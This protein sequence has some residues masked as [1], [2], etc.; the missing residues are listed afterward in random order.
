MCDYIGGIVTTSTPLQECTA[1][2]NLQA[3]IDDA[4]CYETV[5]A[6]RWPDGVGCPE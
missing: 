1:M 3:L 4:K 6:M 2:I 5:R